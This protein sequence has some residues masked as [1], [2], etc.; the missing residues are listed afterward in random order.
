MKVKVQKVS[1]RAILPKYATDGSAAFDL[2]VLLD[3][4]LYLNPGECR[5]LSTGLAFQFDKQYAALI[6]P[7]SG[8]GAKNGIVLGNLLGLCDSDYTGTYGITAWNR[9]HDG[10][11]FKINDGDR[12]AQCMIVPVVHAEFEVVDS[13]S[14]TSRNANGFGSSGVK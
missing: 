12:L 1:P 3:E 14:E 13:L 2:H 7:R 9:N 8:L 11:A 10:E 4:P 5:I 6:L